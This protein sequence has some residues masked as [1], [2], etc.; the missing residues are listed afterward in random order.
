MADQKSKH[1]GKH[2]LDAV[3]SETSRLC[4]KMLEFCWILADRVPLRG[5]NGKTPSPVVPVT[6][7]YRVPLFSQVEVVDEDFI[8]LAWKHHTQDAK[9][10]ILNMTS[11]RVPG[12]DWLS[13]S[14]SWEQHLFRSSTISTSLPL[15]LLEQKVFPLKS[16]EGL[17]SPNVLIIRDDRLRQ[18][19]NSR[20]DGAFRVGVVSLAAPNKPDLVDMRY[21][22]ADA[23][24]IKAKIERLFEIARTGSYTIVLAG[25][26]G[27]G[28]QGNPADEMARVWAQ[29]IRESGYELYFKV[30]FCIKGKENKSRSV[31]QRILSP[32]PPISPPPA[33]VAGK[34]QAFAR[35]KV[36][37]EEEEEEQGEQEDG[38]Q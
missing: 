37:L 38:E 14:K 1:K 5:L 3:A 19:C 35:H 30:I 33:S 4:A 34:P 18:V 22:D 20:G 10:L 36:E 7:K 13:G 31:F 28:L 8:S 26:W 9:I 11:E 17:Y 24:R 16:D 12:G 27:C 23:A 2:S 32:V 6:Q 25:A 15:T 29:V 21:K